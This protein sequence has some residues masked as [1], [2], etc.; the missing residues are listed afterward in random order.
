MLMKNDHGDVYIVYRIYPKISKEPIY[1]TD[2]ESLVSETLRSFRRALGDLK[3]HINFI[4]DNC[5]TNY[6]SIIYSIFDKSNI[7][8]NNVINGGNVGTFIIQIDSALANKYSDIIYFAEDD[9]YYTDKSLEHGYNHII[10][11]PEIDF[12]TLYFNPDYLEHSIHL[13]YFDKEVYK[14][15]NWIDVSTTCLTFFARR[16]SLVRAMPHFLTYKKNNYDSSIFLS[17]TKLGLFSKLLY[18]NL[19]KDMFEGKNEVLKIVAKTFLFGFY[20][21]L[22]GS[23]YKLVSTTKPIATHL[24][25]DRLSPG[26]DWLEIILRSKT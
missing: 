2:K 19:L 7:C 21:V 20:Q 24:Q 1:F 3:Y 10:Q 5:P 23:R 6:E 22:L 25:S 9:Y 8:I 17:L 12:L 16:A 13:P 4:L 15:E 18:W 26:A 11:N 14:R